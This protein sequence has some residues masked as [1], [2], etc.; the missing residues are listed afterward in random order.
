MS[1]LRI[2][3]IASGF[4]TDQIVKDLMRIERM[5][6]DKFYQQRQLANWQKVQFREVI[7]S[8]RSFKDTFFNVLK[9]ETNLLSPTSLKKMQV[10]SS[11]PE[12]VTATANANALVGDINFT[13]YQ[14]ATAAKAEKAGVSAGLQSSEA[15]TVP[16][17]VVEG[18]NVIEAT[19]NG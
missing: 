5:K 10:A 15:I 2:G 11:S 18:K 9:P 17:T 13:V 14:N 6:V 19:L 7:N 16:V 4:D 3:G 1:I 8:I 12:V